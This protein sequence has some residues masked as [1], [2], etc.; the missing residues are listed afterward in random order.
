MPPH[1]PLT[2]TEREKLGALVNNISIYAAQIITRTLAGLVTTA[3]GN[4]TKL[5]NEQEEL[6]KR[7]DELAREQGEESPLRLIE[8][9]RRVPADVAQM[10]TLVR[11][12][13]AASAFLGH[14]LAQPNDPQLTADPMKRE[15]LLH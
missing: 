15:T 9:L 12:C 14:L 3:L 2:A 13:L 1:L 4:L 11:R 7:V 10:L 6:I 8:D 5:K